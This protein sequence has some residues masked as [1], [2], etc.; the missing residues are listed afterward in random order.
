[1]K[2]EVAG[3]IVGS[4]LAVVGAYFLQPWI[5]LLGMAIDCFFFIRPQNIT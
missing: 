1:M 3:Y 2:I 4:A 5:F